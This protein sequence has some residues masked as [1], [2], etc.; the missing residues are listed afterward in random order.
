MASSYGFHIKFLKALPVKSVTVWS[1]K[2]RPL[3][4]TINNFGAIKYIELPKL[5]IC[6]ICLC[7]QTST[8]ILILS[9]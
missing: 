3:Y 9:Y 1:R 8:M 6:P 5:L 2:F 4:I 7:A